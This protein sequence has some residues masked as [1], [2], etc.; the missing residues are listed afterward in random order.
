MDI[1][2]FASIARQL[3]DSRN[4]RRTPLAGLRMKLFTDAGQPMAAIEQNPNTGSEWATKA[5]AGHKV[6]QF[7][8]TR[9]NRYVAVSVD[10]EVKPY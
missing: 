10:G 7:R 3:F 2:L 1:G 8:D 9:A 5:K 6:V 4:V